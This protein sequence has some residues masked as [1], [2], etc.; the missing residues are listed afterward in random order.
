M[1]AFGAKKWDDTM[2]RGLIFCFLSL[3]VLFFAA[4]SCAYQVKRVISGTIALGTTEVVT[5]DLDDLNG[6]ATPHES[7][8]D[9]KLGYSTPGVS[10][11]AR[12][13]LDTSKC[14]IFITVSSTSA[15]SHTVADVFA[16]L[17]DETNISFIRYTGTAATVDYTI[18]EFISGVT[19]V[20]GITV[21]GDGNNA[22]A[23]S[24]TITFTANFDLTRT[25][26][27]INWKSYTNAGSTTGDDVYQFTA[28]FIATNKLKIQRSESAN[29][30]RADMF[31]QIVTFDEDILVQSGAEQMANNSATH[32][33]NLSG[34]YTSVNT[35]KSFLL[36]YFRAGHLDGGTSSSVDGNEALSYVDGAV[37]N[38][39][40][41]TFS[42]GGTSTDADEDPR[43]VWYL[44][45]FKDEAYVQ[46]NRVAISSAT[47]ADADQTV[48]ST[49]LDRIFPIIS[50][51]Y[52]S[53]TAN[54]SG[55]DEVFVRARMKN[56]TTLSLVREGTFS[57]NT[58]VSH[59][60]V[61]LPPLKVI[62]PDGGETLTVGVPYNIQ[63]EAA[64]DL[65]MG[66]TCNGTNHRLTL[67]AY[68]SGTWQ[69]ID[70]TDTTTT[71]CAD[72][73][74][75]SWTPPATMG[76]QNVIGNAVKIRISS[77]Q[78][79]G[80][81][82]D[83][84]NGDF[85][86]TGSLALTS[87]VGS[88]VW[89]IGDNRSITWNR[90]GNLGN[91]RIFYS[92]N[93]GADGYPDPSQLI[94]TVGANDAD[95]N[96]Y[97]WNPV[98]DLPYAQMKIKIQQDSDLVTAGYQGTGGLAAI[99]SSSPGNFE[100]RPS[101]TVVNPV[102][103]DSFVVGRIQTIEWASTG[104]VPNVNLY[105]NPGGTGYVALPGVTNPVTGTTCGS[106]KCYDWTLS[107][108][109]VQN[110]NVKLK[111]EKSDN[112]NVVDEGP[113]AGDGTFSI[114]AGVAI[115]NPPTTQLLRV[116]DMVNIDWTHPGG[117][118]N[119]SVKYTTNWTTCE[120]QSKPV[121]DVCWGW[122]T[123]TTPT[124]ASNLNPGVSGGTYSWQVPDIIGNNIGIL[125][126]EDANPTLVYD[127]RGPF[128]VKGKIVVN[129]PDGTA[130]LRVGSTSNI[131]WDAFG[132]I[133]Q[134]YISLAKDGVSY[135]VPIVDGTMYVLAGTC[136][137][138]VVDA[139][140]QSYIWGRSDVYTDLGC[141]TP[142]GT[143]PDEQCST[144]TCKVKVYKTTEP[145]PTTGAAD[146]SVAFKLVGNISNVVLDNSVY[147]IGNTATISWDVAPASWSTGVTIKRS[148]NGSTWTPIPGPQ[149]TPSTP[150][151]ANGTA[152]V[153]WVIP[154][155]DLIYPTMQIR[156]E[157]TSDAATT[158]ADSGQF[159]IKGNI[160]ITRPSENGGDPLLTWECGTQ[161]NI[162]W[163]VLGASMG[164]VDITY[165][166]NSG[167]DLYI[168][169]IDNSGSVSSQTGS[170]A[171]TIPSNSGIGSDSVFKSGDNGKNTDVRI[172]V[173]SH[174]DPASVFS[175]SAQPLTIKSRFTTLVPNGGN[176]T[177]GDPFNITWITQGD[178][179][180]V[181]VLYSTDGGS[182]WGGTITASSTNA[183][184]FLWDPVNCP[185]DND[186]KVKVES[187]SH[188]DINLSSA[189]NITSKG[190]LDITTPSIANVGA[191]A[192][193]PGEVFRINWTT[194]GGLGSNVGL[195]DVYFAAD[196][197]TFGSA[198]AS[199]DTASANFYDWTGPAGVAIPGTTNK[200]K[201]IDNDDSTVS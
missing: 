127:K 115:A 172:K 157:Q 142:A 168:N 158:Y 52:A 79:T 30:R 38:A 200:I 134:V 152:G 67:E 53:A 33:V 132:S 50:T 1:N 74:T 125:L 2:M 65:T 137:P 199:V 150:T 195:V 86:I 113:D 114:V 161:E 111:I 17:D 169:V 8:A 188:T 180:T 40:T 187:T 162:T 51:S 194:N 143:I 133:G 64:K 9:T 144:G 28:E 41:L 3:S 166:K 185:L 198:I 165:S 116:G 73:G 190:K 201:I 117:L 141:T 92:I 177:V 197:S 72:A 48:A 71:V 99:S 96:S 63:W 31:Y 83:V 82:F 109:T 36:T 163:N 159:Q 88:D 42:R 97:A 171:W 178:V 21:F 26:P 13:V 20:S 164:G 32:T 58:N 112:S 184:G 107:P 56:A 179:P 43:F 84:S 110:A 69:I 46:G 10:D 193:V 103:T 19:V 66:G 23:R 175:T 11:P 101:I 182:T 139:S 25:F 129:T 39:T 15:N 149:L 181:K 18:V 16:V 22:A 119:L 90:A 14:L 76:G 183:G 192:L 12:E 131:S 147:L 118:G 104:T 81:N 174:D 108:S 77:Q 70:N 34:S 106:N 140:A 94:A 68:V 57:A 29:A 62:Q 60:A 191:S 45:E 6:N 186:I 7:S 44:V 170:Y 196:G 61:E 102:D 85:T 153:Q 35:A 154:N 100:I 123:M 121:N 27:I 59:Y 80:R 126:Q 49:T 128:T 93:G 145:D 78:I 122:V 4:D 95:P 120:S 173:A 5:L 91:I 167:N 146:E 24:K 156:V 160:D 47:G 98:P 89:A 135:T 87:P 155:E 138:L 148:N 176:I 136:N 130:A 105:Y 151:A 54:T 37:T 75:Y 55:V 189:Q 124:A